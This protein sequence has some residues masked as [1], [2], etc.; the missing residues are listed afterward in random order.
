MVTF[1]CSKTKGYFLNNKFV[2]FQFILLE[3]A[4]IWFGFR[5]ASL[6]KVG[7]PLSNT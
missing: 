4:A 7:E 5:H 1:N 3:D 2:K 6:T